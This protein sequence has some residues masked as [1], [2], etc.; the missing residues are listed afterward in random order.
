MSGWAAVSESAFGVR[1]VSATLVNRC[2]VFLTQVQLNLRLGSP[3][4]DRSV[5]RYFERG[6]NARRDNIKKD[7][8]IGPGILF[9]FSDNDVKL[10][11]TS[12]RDAFCS[13]SFNLCPFYPTIIVAV[14]LIDINLNHYRTYIQPVKSLGTPIMF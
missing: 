10:I 14:V 13:F 12:V 9:S 7:N 3:T 2:M 4:F 11:W 8:W 6:A 5:R 1:R